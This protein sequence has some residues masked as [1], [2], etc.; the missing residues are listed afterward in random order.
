LIINT[1]NFAEESH[2]SK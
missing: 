1:K 2:S